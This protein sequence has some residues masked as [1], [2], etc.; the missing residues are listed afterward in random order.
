[1]AVEQTPGQGVEL[2]I[3]D[4]EL[5]V[6]DVMGPAV[7]VWSVESAAATPGK[8]TLRRCRVEAGRALACRALG[9]KLLVQAE[10]CR[11][12]FHQALLS[13]DACPGRQDWPRRLTWQDRGNEY[14]GNGAWARI[15]GRPVVWDATAWRRLWSPQP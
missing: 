10:A 12:V 15:D 9:G 11:F 5:H 1:L 14:L 8:V 3:T 13:L 4:S 2:S 6:S 7:L